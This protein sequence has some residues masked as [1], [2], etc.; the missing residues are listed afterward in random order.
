VVFCASLHVWCASVRALD[1]PGFGW[2]PACLLSTARMNWCAVRSLR[3]FLKGCTLLAVLLGALGVNCSLL[4]S[5][6]YL[7]L[8]IESRTY[9]PAC[10]AFYNPHQGVV[11]SST[12]SITRTKVW[13]LQ[14]LIL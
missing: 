5:T 14:V 7:S 13:S 6:Y 12:D 10:L 8:L 9:L 3:Y 2:V 4:Y 11:T 1:V